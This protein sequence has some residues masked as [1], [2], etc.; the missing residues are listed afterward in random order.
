MKTFENWEIQELRN[1]FHIYSVENLPTLTAWIE[2]I[3]RASFLTKS[4]IF[5]KNLRLSSI[6]VQKSSF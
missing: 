1:T 2:M 3:T 4:R 6:Y 5:A